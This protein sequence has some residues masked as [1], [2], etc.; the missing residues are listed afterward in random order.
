MNAKPYKALSIIYSIAMA[1]RFCNT[2][3][4]MKPIEG[5]KKYGNECA[6]CKAQR[7]EKAREVYYKNRTRCVCGL[8]ISDANPKEK[9]EKTKS[10]QNFI[11]YGTRSPD[12]LEYLERVGRTKDVCK[13]LKGIAIDKQIRETQGK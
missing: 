4:A 3:K 10:H 9:H 11:E 1:Q 2:C 8:Y 13:I 12:G 6:D 7:I 5:F